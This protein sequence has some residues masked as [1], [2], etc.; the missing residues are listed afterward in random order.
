MPAFSRLTGAL[1][2]T[3]FVAYG[4]SQAGA[5]CLRCA[6]AVAECAAT[7]ACDY[8]ACECCVDCA[9]CVA[10]H[11]EAWDDCCHCFGLCHLDGLSAGDGPASEDSASDAVNGHM[12]QLPKGTHTLGTHNDPSS[13]QNLVTDDRVV[14][15]LPDDAA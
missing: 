6:F 8:P 12:K 13:I 2:L 7:C 11:G 4:T 1:A 5:Q 9:V 14:K 10:S 3:F 15:I